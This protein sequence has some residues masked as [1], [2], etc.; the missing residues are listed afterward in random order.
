M[1]AAERASMEAEIYKTIMMTN[2]EALKGMMTIPR[3][4]ALLEKM[5]AAHAEGRCRFLKPGEDC[6]LDQLGGYYDMLE[7]KYA[8]Q[9]AMVPALAPE[10]AP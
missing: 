5:R 8:P 6:K 7:Q 3:A 1:T 4:R 9:A 2:E 10:F